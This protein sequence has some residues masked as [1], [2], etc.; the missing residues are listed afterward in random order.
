ME[1]VFRILGPLRLTGPAGQISLPAGRER[2][3]VSQ[4]ILN[5]NK[6]VSVERLA[7][8]VWNYHTPSTVRTQI[9]ICIS[10]LR[11]AFDEAGLSGRIVTSRPGYQ[12]VA[13][14][15][16]V[17]LLVFEREVSAALRV[18]K[19]R[20]SPEATAEGVAIARR[21]LGLFTG[22]PL[23]DVGSEV[24]QS[25][26]RQLA[27]RRLHVLEVCLDAQ[28][29][30][31]QAADIIDEL[32]GLV[33]EHPL[34]GRLR[35]LNMKALQQLGRR[36]DALTVY[37][38]A[39]REYRD[40]LGL[41]PDPE[42]RQLHETIL[43]DMSFRGGKARDHE[44]TR[45]RHASAAP[46][47]AL[48]RPK[49]GRELLPVLGSFHLDGRSEELC[50]L[51]EALRPSGAA[52]P[53]ARRGLVSVSGPPGV[54][55]TAFAVEAATRLAPDYPDGQLY[56]DMRRVDRTP[57]G[58]HAVLATF[59]RALGVP[60]SQVPP[61]LEERSAQY[62]EL[63]RGRRVLV[64]LDNAQDRQI[65]PFLT[66]GTDRA[67]ILVTRVPWGTQPMAHRIRLGHLGTDAS[68]SF[69]A[70]LIGASRVSAESEE[71]RRLADRCAGLPL[72]LTALAS[73]LNR[74]PQWPLARYVKDLKDDS[75][76]LDQL[77][78]GGFD[79][80]GALLADYEDLRCAA[81]L[82]LRRLTLWGERSFSSAVVDELLG[83][84]PGVGMG[85][86]DD[87]V[88]RGLVDVRPDGDATES[89][90]LVGLMRLL[91]RER[92][93]AQRDPT[94]EAAHMECL[95]EALRTAM[96]G[97]APSTPGLPDR[98]GWGTRSAGPIR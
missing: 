34:H 22:E 53:G 13:D 30:L 87:L 21:A 33:A 20:S 38:E 45:V 19:Q 69:L 1:P 73:R 14:Q 41:E 74:R 26:A 64:V 86:L 90:R 9:Q 57:V 84:A 52:G 98:Q 50:A 51:R 40:R 3:V 71:A 23:A 46:H 25:V 82:L 61:T 65:L 95:R 48:R 28:L 94:D 97:R 15:D 37:R 70:R 63:L 80:R 88:E 89:Y 47:G 44:E 42:L 6:V 12:L 85:L 49:L 60:S 55:K 96:P 56:H 78:C 81:R 75:V 66:D 8:G 92:M 59:L 35:A 72:A 76:L 32:A 11:R 77:S 58:P 17:D 24:V 79:V 10:R 43:H 62:R 36:A 68:V 16:E 29:D 39:L 5:A 4:L 2:V 7:D 54:G 93:L 31:G 18:I 83:C 67:V 27:Q 91:A